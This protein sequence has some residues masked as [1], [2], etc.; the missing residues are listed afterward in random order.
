MHRTNRLITRIASVLFSD[1]MGSCKSP[2][3]GDVVLILII[4]V[5]IDKLI[6]RT[7]PLAWTGSNFT[8][9]IVGSTDAL[10]DDAV[11]VGVREF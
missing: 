5:N 6:L 8:E 7:A 2:E 1:T 3:M 9:L 4:E 10:S 11:S